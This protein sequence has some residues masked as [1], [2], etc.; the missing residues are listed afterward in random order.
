MGARIGG[1]GGQKQDY[2]LKRHYGTFT[3][4]IGLGDSSSTGAQVKFTVT[5][6]GKEVEKI[7]IRMGSK[8]QV[9][10]V[11]IT[12]EQGKALRLTLAVDDMSCSE[13]YPVWVDPRIA[14]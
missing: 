3:A 12:T 9:I 4:H 14:P 6:D 7:E 11:P 13:S 1:C 8:L 5:V 2:N 10:E